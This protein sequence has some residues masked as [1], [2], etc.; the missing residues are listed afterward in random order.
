MGV[1]IF[2][3]KDNLWREYY[4]P[5]RALGLPRLNAMIAAGDRGIYSDLQWLYY[6]MEQTD[7]MVFAVLQRRRAAL[8][9]CDWEIRQMAEAVLPIAA[10][11]SFGRMNGFAFLQMIARKV[12]W[13]LAHMKELVTT[14]T[15]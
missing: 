1:P 7:P 5:L 12:Q 2:S 3:T 15:D 4:N 9:E 6:F 10:T 13:I 8:L 14:V 11:G